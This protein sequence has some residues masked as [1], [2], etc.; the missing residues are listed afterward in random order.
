MI[1]GCGK[2]NADRR[3]L[4]G[5]CGLFVLHKEQ[6]QALYNQWQS[7]KMS[8]TYQPAVLRR[9]FQPFLT[10]QPTELVRFNPVIHCL[11][12]SFRQQVPT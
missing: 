10:G 2:T 4:C 9:P 6:Q 1:A 12:P 3:G 5:L 8:R 11:P 7:S